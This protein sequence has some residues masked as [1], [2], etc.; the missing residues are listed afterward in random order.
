MKIRFLPL[1]GKRVGD[2]M[3]GTYEVFGLDQGDF[4]DSPAL[5]AVRLP[6]I[7]VIRWVQSSTQ[8]S[9]RKQ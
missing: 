8:D 1:D 7:S 5:L 3:D 4:N 9:P 6:A 2:C